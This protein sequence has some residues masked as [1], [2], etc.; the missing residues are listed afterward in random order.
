MIAAEAALRELNRLQ[1]RDAL[2]EWTLAALRQQ[3]EARLAVSE[4]GA[5]GA[6]GAGRP[7]PPPVEMFAEARRLALIAERDA[8]HEAE[9][10]EELSG[11]EAH[12]LLKRIDAE[13]VA[14][15]GGGH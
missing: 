4:D 7:H 2:P 10:Q 8:L 5:A 12:P 15:G 1:E 13:I 3:Y 14:L 6:D 9:R 11:Q